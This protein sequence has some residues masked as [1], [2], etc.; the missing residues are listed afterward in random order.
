MTMQAGLQTA[1]ILVVDD[2][3]SIQ[4][5]AC[6]IL[7]MHGYT[8]LDP[9]HAVHAIQLCKQHPEPIHLLLTDVLMPYLHGYD[10]ATQAK[11]LRPDIRVLFMSGYEDSHLL[12]RTAPG[13]SILFL[14]KPF[15][16][17][18]LLKKVREALADQPTAL[19]TQPS[20]DPEPAG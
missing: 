1:T 5:L 19:P 15:S 13:E 8:A 9:R 14:Q 12:T 6:R 3:S 20:Q 18:D 10:L 7:A 11:S 17:D 16:A 4:Q 2:E